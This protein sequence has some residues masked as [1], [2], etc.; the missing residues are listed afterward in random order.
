MSL[1]PPKLFLGLLTG[2]FL[3][4]KV[5]ID[6][7]DRLG[8]FKYVE[9]FEDRFQPLRLQYASSSGSSG[10]V[11][12]GEQEEAAS[13]NV[14]APLTKTGSCSVT[15]IKG[16]SLPSS[17]DTDSESH[18]END[19]LQSTLPFEDFTAYDEENG[20]YFAASG[21]VWTY[22]TQGLKA[23]GETDS[24]STTS[25]N[26]NLHPGIYLID[27]PN[28]EAKKLE[29]TSSPGGQDS[30]SSDSKF[31][32]VLPATSALH[33]M[34]YS[35][36][37]RKL[38]VVHHSKKDT[39][40][41]IVEVQFHQGDEMTGS[42]SGVSSLRHLETVRSPEFKRGGLNDIVEGAIDGST[43]FV[44]EWQPAD[45]PE[46]GL[47]SNPALQR[48]LKFA[49]AAAHSKQTRLIRCSKTASSSGS[50]QLTNDSVS[51]EQGISTWTC[52]SATSDRFEAANGLAVTA[53]RKF[54]F[55]SDPPAQVV[56]VYKLRTDVEKGTTLELVHSFTPIHLVDN[57]A[58]ITG[59]SKRTRTRPSA[60][61]VES[62][63]SSASTSSTSS[64]S[65]VVALHGGSIPL[66]HVSQTVCDNGLALESSRI[67]CGRC[68]G[69]LLEMK[70]RGLYDSDNSPG[71]GTTAGGDPSPGRSSG[72][73]SGGGGQQDEAHQQKDKAKDVQVVQQQQEIQVEQTDVLVHDG[74]LFS[75]VSQ[76]VMWKN[77]SLSTR[78]LMGSPYSRGVLVCEY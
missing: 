50:S 63:Q 75:D 30:D 53:D 8:Y 33:G 69:G 23:E 65:S 37:T 15:K 67:A 48:A 60:T 43:F 3:A 72:Q 68:P 49:K 29:I 59:S 1:L 39:A 44:S 42:L 66:P 55:L 19:E 56:Y 40:V 36:A 2:I 64:D 38:Y 41:E 71:R 6:L 57:M 16:L 70:F 4:Y 25:S 61:S 27:I 51:E 17:S 52:E 32:G 73:A 14:D 5:K 35:A 7:V 58:V 28:G 18:T 76:A 34:F 12:E 9:F 31:P 62:T 74:S 26:R 20:L 11:R 46:N 13:R 78:V 22:M 21:D 24:A 10:A 47:Q 54:L 77:A 45:V